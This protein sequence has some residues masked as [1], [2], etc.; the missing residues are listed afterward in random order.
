MQNLH[1][2][3]R[4]EPS[5]NKLEVGDLLFAEYTCPIGAERVRLWT[6]SDY[7]VHV[8]SGRKN[9]HL[10]DGVWET[11]AGDT[12][13]FKKGA[14]EVEQFFDVEFCLLLF[15]LPD[16]LIRGT[17]RNLGAGPGDSVAPPT[18]RASAFRLESS[19]ALTAFLESMRIYFS[20]REKPSEPLIRLKVQ[21]LIVN[22]WTGG[23]SPAL[24][25]YLRSLARA[26]SVPVAEIMEANFHHNLSLDEYA[27]LCHRSRSTFKR[28]FQ[29][30]LGEA[31]GRWLLRRRLD[32]AATLLSSSVKT[33]TEVAFESGFEDVSH[34]SRAFRQRFHRTPSGYRDS[35]SGASPDR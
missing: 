16:A 1:H 35:S 5:F 15:F 8:V 23:S 32:H 20:G 7:L 12:V 13:Y 21:E 3:I 24:A 29:Q 18:A 19:V 2:S 30:E 22:L 27:A 14:V 33:V 17:V 6:H 31:P 26:D 34:F 28:D 10:R 9:W 25:G 4:S 11:R